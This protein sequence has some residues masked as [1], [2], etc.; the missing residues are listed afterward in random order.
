MKRFYPN[1]LRNNSYFQDRNMRL[2]KVLIKGLQKSSLVLLMLSSFLFL[3]TGLKAQLSD[4]FQ[5]VPLLTGLSNATTMQFAPDGRIFILDRYGDVIIYKTDTQTTTIAGTVPVFHQFEDGLLGIAFDP[6]FLTNNYIYLHYSV[7][8]EDKNRVSRFTMNGD[9]LD[10]NSEIILLDW[11]TQRI[12]SFHSGGDMAFD[13][14]GNL[15]IATGDNTNHGGYTKTDETNQ[16]NSA[17]KSSSNTNDLR[18]KILRITPQSNGTYTI[19]S[20]NLFSVGTA[21]TRPE[22]Y[23]MGA[24]NPYR[25]FVDKENT[26]WLFW[27]EVGP[28]ANAPSPTFKAQKVLMR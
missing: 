18:G 3:S 16:V 15:Y 12:L 6:N 9:T 20:G 14:Q 8:G 25:I 11:G 2:A 13:A 4:E 22:I 28:D 23:V 5:Q 26:D 10:L 1:L 17:E 24:R 19:P 21:N 7:V 27:G